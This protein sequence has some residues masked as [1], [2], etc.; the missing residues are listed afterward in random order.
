MGRTS[1]ATA[2]FKLDSILL[3][4]SSFA[5]LI[6]REP[7][8]SR[9]RRGFHQEK[10]SSRPPTFQLWTS[11]GEAVEKT[12]YGREL[13]LTHGSLQVESNRQFRLHRQKDIVFSS[14]FKSV[15]DH[16]SRM[17]LSRGRY[18]VI[19]STLEAETTQSFFFRLV[20]KS[21]SFTLRP[22]VHDQPEKSFLTRKLPTLVTYLK[23]TEARD[24]V[25]K[26]PL[27]RESCIHH[28]NFNLA[29]LRREN[30]N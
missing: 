10:F 14:E 26:S 30:R 15:R 22:L 11:G 18:V 27:S 20:S 9:S 17:E 6:C 3:S 19:V 21:A 1:K 5:L 4:E 24:L 7:S 8:A 2:L 28:R 23:V 25:R 12:Y 13:T 29:V 16:F